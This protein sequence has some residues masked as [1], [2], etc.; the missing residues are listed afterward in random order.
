MGVRYHMNLTT[1]ACSACANTSGRIDAGRSKRRNW[2]GSMQTCAESAVMDHGKEK[3]RCKALVVWKNI[4]RGRNR[5]QCGTTTGASDMSASHRG[6]VEMLFFSD[7]SGTLG[8]DQ[9]EKA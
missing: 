7:C 4:I 1:T 3:S 5:V 8:H 9:A 6:A 2:A